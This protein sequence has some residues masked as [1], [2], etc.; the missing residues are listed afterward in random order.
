MTA[1]SQTVTESLLSFIKKSPT[2]F[3]AVKTIGEM[4]NEA[5]FVRLEEAQEWTLEA[6]KG[7]YVTRNGSSVLAFRMPTERPQQILIS[8]SHTDSPM[9]K[10]K[11]NYESA[12]A[13]AYTRLNTE[14]YGGTILSSW[15]DRPLSVAGR[16]I[17]KNNG[18]FETKTV[19]IDRDLLLIPNVAIHMNRSVN[20]GYAWNPAVD[21]LPLFAQNGSP[22]LGQLLAEEISCMPE[23]IVGHDLY[24]Y[25][26]MDGTVWGSD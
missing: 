9:F 8:A 20:S 18:T 1:I 15:L 2:A 13:G 10:I 11:Q 12:T 24:L 22:T 5:G 14:V 19:C 16:I 7:Y 6:G 25:N 3:H 26:R 21:M 17:L 4:L 23:E